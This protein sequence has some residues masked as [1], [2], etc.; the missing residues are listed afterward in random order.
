MQ[1]RWPSPAATPFYPL[2]SRNSS[3][4]R[5]T[6][7]RRRWISRWWGKWKWLEIGEVVAWETTTYK[8]CKYS[9]NVSFV[10][11]SS[12]TIHTRWAIWYENKE[13]ISQQCTLY[14]VHCTLYI[15][16]CTLYIVQA[17][18]YL[19]FWPTELWPWN[20]PRWPCCCSP[21]TRRL[22]ATQKIP[23][24]WATRP[25]LQYGFVPRIR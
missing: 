1:P 5:T 21:F 16:H 12:V 24:K 3:P 6:R 19:Y 11:C 13:R 18:V 22:L 7:S 14:I 20:S 23:V 15:V 10:N 8:Y 4:T 9:L 25:A 17:A 2:S